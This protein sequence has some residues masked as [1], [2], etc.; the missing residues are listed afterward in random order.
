[1]KK[2]YIFLVLMVLMVATA[3]CLDGIGL[4]TKTG[5]LYGTVTDLQMNPVADLTVRI[6]GQDTYTDLTGGFEFYGLPVGKHTLVIEDKYGVE[7]AREVVVIAYGS[8]S[9]TLQVDLG[10]GTPPPQTVTLSGYVFDSTG[11]IHP[12]AIVR[13]YETIGDDLY[14]CD[15]ATVDPVT[16]YYFVELDPGTYGVKVIVFPSYA[17]TLHI[18][19]V[20]TS[21]QKDL[22]AW[23]ELPVV[24]TSVA[25]TISWPAVNMGRDVYYRVTV[26]TD[27][28]SSLTKRHMVE[29]MSFETTE[30]SAEIARL[31]SA[32]NFVLHLEAYDASTHELLLHGIKSWY[33]NG[34]ATTREG[35]ERVYLESR[36]A[37]FARSF[38]SSSYAY[39]LRGSLSNLISDTYM[40]N[41][42]RD[43]EMFL[44]ALMSRVNPSTMLFFAQMD[45][46]P[47]MN[48]DVSEGGVVYALWYEA[49]A[50]TMDY[51]SQYVI[52]NFVIDEMGYYYINGGEFTF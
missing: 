23:S 44:D 43:K 22:Y 7:L 1:M 24:D 11:A 14:M 3:G 10:G 50:H 18:V 31:H 33:I 47:Y 41:L 36:M 16:G 5:D 29:E 19:D 4:P 38:N 42:G 28:I 51:V 52:L 30:T 15:D 13:I 32:A 8:N 49:S 27:A 20:N 9:K 2:L 37:E 35:E 12:D 34:Y 45:A 39:D 25:Q 17:E 26:G 48:G 6:Y 40:D 21:V 46:M